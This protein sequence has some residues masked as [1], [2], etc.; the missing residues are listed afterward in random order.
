M[1]W[2]MKTT[3]DC[4]V[5]GQTFTR[6]HT[7][8]KP[9]KFCSRACRNKGR[10]V[11]PEVRAKQGRKGPDH[12]GFKGGCYTWSSRGQRYFMTWLGDQR[13]PTCNKRGYIH[14]SHLAWNLAHPDSPVVPGQI[15]HHINGDSLDDRAENLEVMDQREHARDHMREIAK[16]RKRDALGQFVAH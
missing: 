2:G 11:P 15:V 5:C 12:P 4:P 9:P 10:Y 16:T 1:L 7:A 8:E 13:W 6:I 3:K 14:R